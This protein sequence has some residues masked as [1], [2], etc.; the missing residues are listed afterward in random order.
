MGD[1]D[2]GLEAEAL[3]AWCECGPLGE[4]DDR[5]TAVKTRYLSGHQQ[6][7]RTDH[8]QTH[9]LE[10]ALEEKISKKRPAF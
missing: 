8:E 9:V 6:L 4:I 2:S 7:L 5:P 10:E 3:I 1:D